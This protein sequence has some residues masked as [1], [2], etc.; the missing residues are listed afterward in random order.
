MTSDWQATS[1]CPRIARQLVFGTGMCMHHR[2]RFG[3]GVHRPIEGSSE[4]ST[5]PG[6]SSLI[7]NCTHY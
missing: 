6:I 5:K 4:V 7:A 3:S 2:F 1:T